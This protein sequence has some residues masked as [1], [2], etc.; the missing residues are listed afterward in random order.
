[1]TRFTCEATASDGMKNKRRQDTNRRVTHGSRTA[2]CRSVRV[3]AV[4][5]IVGGLWS[6]FLSLQ[7]TQIQRAQVAIRLAI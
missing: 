7:F 6:A 2:V 1:M 3:C 4:L 5:P